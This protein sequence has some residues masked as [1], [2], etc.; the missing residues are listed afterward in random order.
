MTEARRAETMFAIVITA[1][2]QRGAISHAW[3]GAEVTAGIWAVRMRNSAKDRNVPITEPTDLSRPAFF[4]TKKR[5][6]SVALYFA[7]QKFLP[8]ESIALLPVPQ[9]KRRGAYKKGI[10][11]EPHCAI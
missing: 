8:R 1:A 5:Y 10:Q 11:T 2:D 6:A 4:A 9:A 7:Y 3:N